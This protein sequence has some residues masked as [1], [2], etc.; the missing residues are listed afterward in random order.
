MFSLLTHK[1]VSLVSPAAWWNGPLPVTVGYGMIVRVWV[2]VMWVPSILMGENHPRV[3]IAVR[4]AVVEAI[5]GL[6]VLSHHQ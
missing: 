3:A 2:V 1:N 4:V 6:M 5:G